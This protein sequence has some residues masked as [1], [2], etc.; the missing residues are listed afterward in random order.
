MLFNSSEFAF[1]FPIVTT[2]YFLLPYR[3]QWLFLLFASCVFY[4]AFIPK[5]IL[6]LFALILIDYAAG[7]AIASTQTPRRKRAILLISLCSNVGLLAAF[8]YFNFFAVNL[9]EFSKL[10]GWNYS[11]QTLSWILPIGLSFH[12][13]QSMAYT[14]EVYYGRR[15]PER[16][17]GIY[18]LYVLFYP[19]M[20][21]GP[22]E[23]PQ[24]LLPQL[25]EPHRFDYD[26]AV[27]G[28]K[29]MMSGM[30]KKVVVADHLAALVNPVYNHPQLYSGWSALVAT[31]FFAFQIYCDF[32]GYSD[33]ARGA[34]RV[35]GFD[36]MVNFNYPY[37]ARSVSEFWRR[38][39]I[40]LSTW[41]RD[42]L[43]LPL[44]GNRVAMWRR[45]INVMIVFLVSGFWH[46]ANWTFLV[47][48]GLH[49]L[50]VLT[51][52]FFGIGADSAR[53]GVWKRRLD[54]FITFQ[55]VCLAWIFFRIDNVHD[56][57]FMVRQIATSLLHPAT[58]LTSDLDPRSVVAGVTLV[59]ALLLF[60]AISRRKPLWEW[61][62]LQPVW[63]RWPLYYACVLLLMRAARVTPQT[64][65]YFQF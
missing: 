48:G 40:S 35:M 53:A 52:R 5:Y 55:L 56:G 31:W 63:V 51:E 6:I 49:G 41:F 2:I 30:L 11:L 4:M 1:F 64:F 60:E 18:A 12:T 50:Y 39:H 3:G 37:I 34:A 32:S 54:V 61:T 25:H 9:T 47:W 28:V 58:L 26:R 7:L 8:K 65:I 13:F 27:S 16:H 10:I 59:G 44:G 23:R 62:A 45:S 46:G 17:L 20:V 29:L 42:Y 36:L 14:I 24:N 38:W 22:I 57:M 19:Q 21:A 15:E 33:I 43:Y